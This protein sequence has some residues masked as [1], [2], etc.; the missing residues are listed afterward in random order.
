MTQS[1]SGYLPDRTVHLH[2]LARCNLAC[3]H[4]Y[5]HSNPQA[6]DMLSMRVLAPALTQLREE[7]YEVLSLSGGE[8]MLYPEL[9]DLTRHAKAL[10]FRVVAISNGFRMNAKFAPLIDTFDGLAISFDGLEKVHNKVRCNPRAY[11]MALKGLA[12]LADSGKPVAAAYT[13]SKESLRDIP[14]FVEIAADLGARAVQLRPLVMAGR[15]SDDYADYALNKADRHRL[16]LI[17]QALGAAYDGEIAIHTDLAHAD[18]IYAN[19]DAF[20]AVLNGCAPQLSDLVNPLV[21]TPQG[22]MLPYT[23]DFPKEY[24]L[25]HISDIADRN[26]AGIKAAAPK[27]RRLLHSVFDDIRTQ[28]DFIDWFAHTRDFARGATLTV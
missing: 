4:C 23:Y 12:Y 10:G 19:R 21:I 8:P 13:V 27:L 18:D 28:D 11:D 14:E 17:G 3:K 20:A 1:R 15:A 26:T 24:A 25:G 2:P 5:S 9:E 6:S 7:G 16:W 22:Q